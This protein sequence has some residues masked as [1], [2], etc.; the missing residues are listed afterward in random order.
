MNDR[1]SLKDH[2]EQRPK[3][4]QLVSSGNTKEVLRAFW[5]PEDGNDGNSPGPSKY[6]RVLS[7]FLVK[8][9]GETI[10]LETIEAEKS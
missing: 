5:K 1:F 8:G 2:D 3:A 10:S 6:S 7:C 9:P 4:E